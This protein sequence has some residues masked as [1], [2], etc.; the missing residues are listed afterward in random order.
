MYRIREEKGFRSVEK[1]NGKG[2]GAMEYL[3]TYGWAILVVLIVGVILWQLGIFN[4]LASVANTSTGFFP[5]KIGII[6]AATQCTENGGLSATFTNQAG[7]D[8]TITN[9]TATGSCTGTPIPSTANLSA[10]GKL[11][12]QVGTCTGADKGDKLSTTLTVY[13]TEHVAGE[14]ITRTQTGTIY[15]HVES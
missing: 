13:F 7:N 11:N 8:L 9:L 6:D 2:Q 14:T 4:G 12:W 15:C 3:M 10:G 1:I 5:G